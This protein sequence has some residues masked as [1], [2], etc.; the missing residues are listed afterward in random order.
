MENLSTNETN[1]V[2]VHGNRNEITEA[3]DISVFNNST[4]PTT[5][6]LQSNYKRFTATHTLFVLLRQLSGNVN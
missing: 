2:V 6:K 3:N 4:S 5:I 1:S